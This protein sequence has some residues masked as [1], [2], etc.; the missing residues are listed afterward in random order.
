MTGTEL[1][2]LVAVGKRVS[3]HRNRVHLELELGKIELT[4]RVKQP[5]LIHRRLTEII[6]KK[7]AILFYTSLDETT[8]CGIRIVDRCVPSQFGLKIDIKGRVDWL[9]Q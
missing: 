2:E 6:G 8:I 1:Q 3:L 4:F 5:G 9:S 7:V